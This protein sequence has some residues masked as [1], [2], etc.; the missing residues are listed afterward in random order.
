MTGGRVSVSI[1]LHNALITTP[2]LLDV[3]VLGY[4]QVE[5]TTNNDLKMTQKWP[6]KHTTQQVQVQLVQG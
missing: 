2:Q 6:K 5:N 4:A 3:V 1:P